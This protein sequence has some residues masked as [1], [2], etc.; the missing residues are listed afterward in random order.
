MNVLFIGYHHQFFH[1]AKLL[2]D[3]GHNSYIA[4]GRG[5]GTLDAYSVSV[6]LVGVI[7]EALPAVEWTVE[8]CTWLTDAITTHSIT[9]VVNGIPWAAFIEAMMPAGVVY[10]GPTVSAAELETNKFA[11]RAAVSALGLR[12][13]TV[14]REGSSSSITADLAAITARPL[15]IKPKT[16]FTS[17]I[18]VNTGDD[19]AV[20]SRLAGEDSYDYYFEEFIPNMVKEAEVIFTVANGAWSISRTGSING[21]ALTKGVVPS[22]TSWIIHTVTAPLTSSEDTAVR[23]FAATFLDMAKA[24]GGAYCG[25]LTVGIDNAGLVYW[26]EVNTR[27]SSPNIAPTFCS[28]AEYIQ[29]LTSDP[30][31]ITAAWPANAKYTTLVATA[32]TT[33]TYP[34]DLHA[35][36]SVRIPVGLRKDGEIY[37]LDH[38]GLLLFSEGDL[39]SGFVTAINA[40]GTCTI[41]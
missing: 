41:S 39:P 11:T 19:A 10:L 14:L 35:T 26:L 1:Q 8:N 37:N 23:A 12:T 15:I 31:I 29:S 16:A 24:K 30:S 28:A 4:T 9:H 7:K 32:D 38:N 34:F 20:I 2:V 18:I 33:S 17:T 25:E 3:A 5:T 21:E 27:P 40:S 22:A 36:H 13:T 6:G